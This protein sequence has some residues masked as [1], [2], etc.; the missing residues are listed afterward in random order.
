MANGGTIR[1]IGMRM[2]KVSYIDKDGNWT[3]RPVTDEDIRL[4]KRDGLLKA[5]S[6]AVIFSLK[7]S[8]GREVRAIDYL[9][10]VTRDL[11]Y[12]R[13]EDLG[14]LFDSVVPLCWNSLSVFFCDDVFNAI[15]SK[16][17]ESGR[18]DLIDQ[19]LDVRNEINSHLDQTATIFE[20]YIART[21]SNFGLADDDIIPGMAASLGR[22][23]LFYA[24]DE[25]ISRIEPI[26]A[27]VARNRL[28]IYQNHQPLIEKEIQD[29]FKYS[30]KIKY[31]ID[32]FIRGIKNDIEPL[33]YYRYASIEEINSAER[34]SFSTSFHHYICYRLIPNAQY[35]GDA[36]MPRVPDWVF[37]FKGKELFVVPFKYADGIKKVLDEAR[38]S[39]PSQALIF[40]KGDIRFCFDE[41]RLDLIF[42]NKTIYA[43]SD[44]HVLSKEEKQERF[45]NSSSEQTVVPQIVIDECNRL[46]EKLHTGKHIENY[47]LTSD[48]Q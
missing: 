32:A 31:R 3:E 29:V 18:A 16:C 34:T 7:S 46:L 4:Y 24:L 35:Y 21:A 25:L 42:G 15:A 17:S 30:S 22:F 39:K 37:N 10:S 43:I 13:S 8:C 5:I 45:I 9:R 19:Y 2:G 12:N 14:L 40:D 48:A 6:D 28:C 1:D 20:D 41:S 23:P 27:D 11:C 36:I 47:I 33:H 26:L 38:S 44:F